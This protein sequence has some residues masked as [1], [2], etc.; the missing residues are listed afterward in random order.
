M[1]ASPETADEHDDDGTLSEGSVD[2]SV[3]RVVTGPIARA[4]FRSVYLLHQ[5]MIIQCPVQRPVMS[6]R[7][8]ELAKEIDAISARYE[9]VHH[10]NTYRAPDTWLW[11]A[12]DL[13]DDAIRKNCH[14]LEVYKSLLAQA[15]SGDHTDGPSDLAVWC[16]MEEPYEGAPPPTGV[17]VLEHL[18]HSQTEAVRKLKAYKKW[19]SF[20]SARKSY[21]SAEKL[22]YEVDGIAWPSQWAWHVGPYSDS[23][24]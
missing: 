9:A 2:R 8:H 16:S 12:E 15:E 22:H 10:D 5:H 20:A 13:L 4:A 17:E 18:L 14:L 19:A 21:Y 11:D 3:N 7:P 23:Y 1:V 24:G 6:H